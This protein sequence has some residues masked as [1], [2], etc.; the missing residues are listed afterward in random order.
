V[1][2][3]DD[4]LLVRNEIR[5]MSA[6]GVRVL[7]HGNRITRN[8]IAS[9]QASRLCD[10]ARTTPGCEDILDV[11]GVGVWIAEGFRNQLSGNALHG[12]DIDL[13]D[14]GTATGIRGSR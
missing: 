10:T 13:I 3:G 1:V 12:N 4:N 7:G 9:T 14:Q 11:C 8:S 6:V 2:F 5:N